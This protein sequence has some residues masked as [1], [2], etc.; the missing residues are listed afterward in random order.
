[1]KL[2]GTHTAE[3]APSGRSRSFGQALSASLDSKTTGLPRRTATHENG[4]S[5][6]HAG[7]PAA[8]LVATRSRCAR[9][10]SDSSS[11]IGE[12]LR[13]LDHRALDDLEGRL[14]L[15]GH[16]ERLDELAAE[17]VALRLPGQL[18][19]EPHAIGDVARVQHDAADV[20][21]VA[22]IG[23]MSL[24]VAPLARG[25][26]HAGRRA[27]AACRSAALAATA[28][29]RPRGRT[30]GIR[31]EQIGLAAPERRGHRVARVAAAVLAEH[32]HEVGRGRD[33]AAEVRGLPPRRRRR[34]PRPAAARRS[35]R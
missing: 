24:E 5:T 17:V 7:A 6:G 34:A 11:S 13:H 14:L 25:V 22:K 3:H 33:E 15:V 20:A 16:L 9:L 26:A 8:G 31:P 23:Q 21:V 10:E 1:M 12:R 2:I 30:A 4:D 19:L 35:A 28:R 18:L 32:E 29:D 27:A